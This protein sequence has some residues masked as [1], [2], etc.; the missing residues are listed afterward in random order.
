MGKI[1]FTTDVWTDPN[2]CPFMALTAHWIKPHFI[3]TTTGQQ[4][5]LELR[6]DLI[7]F[8]RVPGRHT[9]VHLAQCF[10]YI[11]DRFKI[12]HKVCPVTCFLI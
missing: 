11:I 6:A 10:L 5:K 4:K 1:S 8:L 12:A 9:G 2:L 7:G 3:D